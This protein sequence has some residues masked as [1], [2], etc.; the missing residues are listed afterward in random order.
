MWLIQECKRQ[1]DLEKEL[2]WQDIVDLSN[3]ADPLQSFINP[4]SPGFLNPD[5][6]P[7]AIQNYCRET[8]QKVPQSKGEIARCIYDSLVLKYKFTIEQIENITGRKIEKLHVI[9]GGAN[10][11]VLN[12]LISNATGISVIS[13]PSEATAIGNLMM[14]AK[15]LG[16]VDTVAEIR[17]IVKESFHMNICYPVHDYKWETAFEKFKTFL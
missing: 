5:N 16:A 6:M 11:E 10:N 2:S 9:G 1:W 4:D 15:A 12:Q 13:G 7:E 17:A 14:Q 8:H 3:H